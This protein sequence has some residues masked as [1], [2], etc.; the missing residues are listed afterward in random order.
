MNKKMIG[1]DIGSAFL[2]AVSLTSDFKGRQGIAAFTLIDLKAAGG[3]EQ[4]L[5]KLF[6]DKRFSGGECVFSIPAGSC[7]FRNLSLPF[8]EKKTID[9]I[10]TYEMEPHIP[11]PIE[12]VRVDSLPPRY[13]PES[14]TVLAAAARKEDIQEFKR[15]V[16]GG[17]TAIIDTDAVPIALNMMDQMNPDDSW[18]LVDIGAH[19]SVAVFAQKKSIVHVRSFPLGIAET[20]GLSG[21]FPPPAPDHRDKDSDPP[22][23]QPDADLP[24][25]KKTERKRRQLCREIACTLQFLSTNGHLEESPSCIYLTGGGSLS[26]TLREE[27]EAFFNLPVNVVDLPRMKGIALP[28][29]NRLSW[30]APLMNQ[31]VALALRGGSGL[32]SFNFNKGEA[33]GSSRANGLKSHLRWTAVMLAILFLSLGTNLFAGYYADSRKLDR[34]RGEI[35]RTFKNSCPEVT[36]IVDPVRQLQQKISEARGLSRGTEHGARFLDSWK[37]AMDTLPESSGILVTELNYN[38]VGLEI[39]GEVS[40]FQAISHWKDEL[41][42][43]RSFSNIQM[44]FGSSTNKDAKKTFKLRMTHVF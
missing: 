29:K 15:Y 37:K 41:E 3:K 21:N 43:S 36:R 38:Q 1:I 22:I 11:Y 28:E 23:E 30:N 9:E 35:T 17:T 12:A 33:A 31:A 6:E 20:S 4:A 44:Q 5:R 13:T 2:K 39:S 40:D 7:S 19:F 25:Q 27:L 42:K 10:I 32:Q 26:G 8:T 14:T 16:T 18:L 34:I 24:Y